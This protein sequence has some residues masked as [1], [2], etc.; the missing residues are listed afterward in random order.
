MCFVKIPLLGVIKRALYS[1]LL[2]LSG[3]VNASDGASLKA[4]A[5]NLFSDLKL[6][7]AQSSSRMPTIALYIANRDDRFA[8]QSVK[9]SVDGHEVARYSYSELETQT[10][11][12]GGLHLLSKL[13]LPKENNTISVKFAVVDVEAGPHAERLY[14]RFEK[15]ISVAEN[16]QW[17]LELIRGGWLKWQDKVAI[18][19]HDR[20]PENS[21]SSGD[22]HPRFR[23][24]YFNA[25]RHFSFDAL[26]DAMAMIKAGV[27]A[28]QFSEQVKLALSRSASDLGLTEVSVSLQGL[29]E[30]DRLSDESKPGS[31]FSHFNAGAALIQ[32]GKYAEG[33]ALLAALSEGELLAPDELLL[34]DKVNLALGYHFLKQ[35]D[36]EQ[37][38]NYF[39]QVRRLSPYA[40]KALVGL[41][42]ALLSPRQSQAAP[43]VASDDHA[44]EA[45]ATATPYLWSGSEDEIAWARRHTPFRRAWAIASGGKEEDLQAAMVPWME[46]VNRDPLDPAVQEGLLILPY[47]MSHWAGQAQ[48]AERY[49][50]AAS[51]RLQAALQSLRGASA[52]IQRGGLR[53]AIDLADQG[54]RS[55]WDIWLSALYDDKDA[56]FDLLIDSPNFHEALS[57]YRQLVRIRDLLG[58]YQSG[59]LVAVDGRELDAK[60]AALLPRLTASIAT[61]AATLDREALVEIGR[62]QRRTEMYLAEANFALARNHENTRR[63]LSGVVWD[64]EMTR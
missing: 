47:V 57:E 26:A 4:E 56:Y 11:L 35:G 42:W 20:G 23:S 29:V 53:A 31:M 34:R 9:L 18:Q 27:S 10:L 2:L 46:L 43:L 59:P 12:D 13:A 49:Y 39:S 37:A 54:G 15:V 6:A 41:G 1:V 19:M 55:G 51:E 28:G 36:S 64:G 38:V 33:V 50:V 45:I 25:K 3:V 5:L 22:S 60:F 61:R 8:I 63:K 24:M 48:R 21:V 16:T 58:A 30:F 44:S 40:N 14:P 62:H 32:Q 7:E 52:D 17:E